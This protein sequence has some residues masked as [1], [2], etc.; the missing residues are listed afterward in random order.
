MIAQ[1]LNFNHTNLGAAGF[2]ST[3]RELGGQPFLN[4]LEGLRRLP[5]PIRFGPGPRKG[6]K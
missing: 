5:Q 6:P 2:A 4:N 3:A 1:A